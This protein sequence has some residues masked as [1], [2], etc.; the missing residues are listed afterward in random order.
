MAKKADDDVK[1]VEAKRQDV[2]T[3]VAQRES[4]VRLKTALLKKRC[5]YCGQAAW[6]VCRTDGEIRYIKCRG[7][8][9]NDKIVVAGAELPEK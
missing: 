8:G 1:Q 6:E 2:E 9:R 5:A 7:C 4:D 3:T